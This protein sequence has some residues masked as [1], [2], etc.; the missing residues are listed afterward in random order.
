MAIDDPFDLERFVVA[1]DG[2]GTYE[3]T[4]EEA[5]GLE[6]TILLTARP[7]RVTRSRWA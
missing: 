6:P 7:L 5:I 1:Q 4:I 2:G 3:Q